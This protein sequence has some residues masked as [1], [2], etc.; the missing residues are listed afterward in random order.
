[1]T[2]ND[3]IGLLASYAYAFGLLFIVEAIGK[4]LK[5]PVHFTRK[6][7][8]IGAGLWVW[9]ILYYFDHW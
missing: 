4:A 2:I 6:I 7:I 5:W 9:G 1:M 3:L 8:H